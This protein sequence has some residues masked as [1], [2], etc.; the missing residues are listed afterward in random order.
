MWRHLFSLYWWRRSKL[1]PSYSAGS[2]TDKP[3]ESSLKKNDSLRTGKGGRKKL[4]WQRLFVKRMGLSYL[5]LLTLVTATA[6]GC[7]HSSRSKRPSVVIVPDSRVVHVLDKKTDTERL[8]GWFVISPGHWDALQ[9]GLSE[10]TSELGQCL[11]MLRGEDV[12]KCEA[13]NPKPP[14]NPT[15]IGP[16]WSAIPV[17]VQP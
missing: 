7:L 17:R 8:D 10:K 11:C 13:D 6:Q 14:A 15:P 1:C 5:L 3:D 9:D 4:T 16:R 2:E 12:S